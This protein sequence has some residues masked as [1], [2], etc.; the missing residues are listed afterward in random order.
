MRYLT[1]V[2]LLLA[3]LPW[4]QQ[5]AWAQQP[6]QPA[7]A[8]TS[9]QS[10]SQSPGSVPPEYRPP[11]LRDDDEKAAPA[12]AAQVAPDA[13]VITITGLCA[14]PAA[15]NLHPASH[16]S[17]Q[18]SADPSTQTAECQTVLTRSQF[19]AL[20]DAILT[21]MRPDRKLQ[22]ANAYPGLLAMARAAEARGVDQTPRFQ[23]RLAF[24]RV[25]IL[26][27]E[28]VR[29]I[30]QEAAQV[31]EQDI[32]NYYHAHA[33][34]FQTA[35]L[36][37]IFIPSRRRIDPLPGEQAAGAQ[38]PGVQKNVQTNVQKDVQKDVQKKEA[39]EAMTA[40]AAQLR[41]EAV[42]GADFMTLQKKA[43]E[44]ARA[45]DVPPNPSLGQLR[46]T[47]VPASHVSVFELKPGEVSPVL[48]DSTGHYIYKLDAKAVA[49]L[50]QVSAEIHKII[51]NQRREEAIQAVQRPITTKL[52][53]AYFGA[54][55]KPG[56]PQQP[57]SE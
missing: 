57:K 14:P 44:A 10:P 41:A 9:S 4:T 47:G 29:Q 40:I 28:L 32:A 24:A 2:C 50:P 6:D 48:S 22:L 16:P 11:I 56:T 39:E 49:T 1:V 27:Q 15:S 54:T 20:A 23:E 51:E 17:P 12:S 5:L 36:E 3:G 38:K 18:A 19:E 30:E 7:S 8:S 35:T 33:A 53:P 26:S 25:Q 13:A 45:T 34:D 46:P 52:N 21:N 31:P 37:R 42:A 55:E 43:Y